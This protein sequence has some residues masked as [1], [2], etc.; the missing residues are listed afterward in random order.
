[1][2]RKVFKTA[3]GE[4]T[5]RAEVTAKNLQ[6]EVDGGDSIEGAFVRTGPNA[7]LWTIN[8][9][10]HRVAAVEH[11]G[12][13]WAAVNGRVFRFDLIDP[14]EPQGAVLAENAVAAPMPGKVIKVYRGEGDT[15]EEGEPVIVV[16]AMKMEHTLRAPTSGTISELR[17]A[18]GDQV[19]SG[20]PLLE[21]DA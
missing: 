8:G 20:V 10:R 13:V 14:D 5:L 2:R 21:I 12:S 4:R 7:G 9:V 15:V 1:M 11:N 18:E 6:S 3:D 19:D 16:E 17:C